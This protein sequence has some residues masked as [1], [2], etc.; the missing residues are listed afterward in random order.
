VKGEGLAV[1]M[2]PYGSRTARMGAGILRIY[3]FAFSPLF[4][5]VCRFE[6]S[7]SRY[8]EEALH[9][10]GVARGSWLTVRRVLR[11]HPF[12]PGGLDPVP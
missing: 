1:P 12:H 8:G 10:H 4:G 3:R 6:P 5:N 11:C 7:C 9:R 2:P